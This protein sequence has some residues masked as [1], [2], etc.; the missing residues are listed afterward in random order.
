ME[1]PNEDPPRYG[2]DSGLCLGWRHNRTVSRIRVLILGS[3]GSFGTQAL[4]VIAASPDRVEVLGLAAGGSSPRL[5]GQQ[6]AQT[7]VE[8]I[9]VSDHAGGANV[10]AGSH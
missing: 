8:N 1:H 7:G 9:A 4:D 2:G 6:R 3:T 5:L 10:G